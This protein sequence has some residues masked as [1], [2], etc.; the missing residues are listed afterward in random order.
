MSECI[1]NR[2]CKIG[3]ISLFVLLFATTGCDL[4]KSWFEE[5][6]EQTVIQPKER[7]SMTKLSAD[8][9]TISR[10][11]EVFHAQNGRYPDSLD[12]LARLG[13]LHYIPREPFGGE[14]I[15]DRASGNVKS[16]VYPE[17]TVQ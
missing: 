17:V 8:L 14:W 15:Y 13:A 2:H 9:R 1:K 11:I 3:F 6:A 5:K 4:F 12:E 10:A 7:A 16:S